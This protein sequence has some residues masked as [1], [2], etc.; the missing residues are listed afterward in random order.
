MKLAFTCSTKTVYVCTTGVHAGPALTDTV[1]LCI[2]GVLNLVIVSN[3][4]LTLGIT[5]V[6][7]EVGFAA[8]KLQLTK[9]CDEFTVALNGPLRQVVCE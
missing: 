7:V 4:K 1:K 5:G 2:P 9:G 6:L 3:A 8:L